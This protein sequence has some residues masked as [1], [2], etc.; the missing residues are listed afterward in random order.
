MTNE[1][2]LTAV[3]SPFSLSHQHRA[4]FPESLPERYEQLSLLVV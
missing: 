2:G 4:V 3:V 1:K